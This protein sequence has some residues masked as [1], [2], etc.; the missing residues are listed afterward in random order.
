MTEG[1]VALR[2]A[3]EVSARYGIPVDPAVVKII[4]RGVSG[5]PDPL[6]PVSPAEARK[7]YTGA[8]YGSFKAKQRQAK[9]Q[10]AAERAAE[11]V[12]VSKP[13]RVAMSPE[14]ARAKANARKADARKVAAATL[15]ERLRSIADRPVA[16]IASSLAM[17]EKGVRM[18]A[19]RLGL[20]LV[21]PPQKPK[22]DPEARR[23][24]LDAARVIANAQRAEAARKR[25]DEVRA[26][27]DGIRTRAEIMAIAGVSRAYLRRVIGQYAAIRPKVD[28]A[29]VAAEI[30]SAM[31]ER[32][33][34]NQIAARIGRAVS[35]VSWYISEFNLT[36]PAPLP[37]VK[38]PRPESQW[39]IEQAA[40]RNRVRLAA[41]DCST[42]P[43]IAA[44][45][46]ISRMAAQ[47]HLNALG[48]CPESGR[49]LERDAAI[50]EDWRNGMAYRHIAAKYGIAKSNVHRIVGR[51][52][53]MAE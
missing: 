26:L 41:T 38:A 25:A 24:A 22:R 23:A 46:G 12:T 36:R 50:I 29:A 9:F 10:R 51:V 31:N 1:D 37:K 39:R 20:A 35:T 13:K 7:A 3:A 48:M 15:A 18:L 27:A 47:R 40:I 52:K 28:G 5:L 14:E 34:L 11:L 42:I 45:V 32:L 53:G 21:K 43:E 49:K 16:E 30:Q 44:R 17:S 4:P 2:V 19:T 33:T 6:A 8:W